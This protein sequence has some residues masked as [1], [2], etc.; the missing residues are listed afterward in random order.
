MIT[1]WHYDHTFGMHAVSGVSLPNEKT[2]EF[3]KKQQEEAEDSGYIEALKREDIHFKKRICRSGQAGY[4]I[5]R[6]GIFGQ[7]DRGSGRNNRPDLSYRSA[8]F[9]RHGLYLYTGREGL[10]FR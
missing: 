7:N 5:V 6:P 8:A 9:R 3:L 10:I 2:N 1:H 4:C